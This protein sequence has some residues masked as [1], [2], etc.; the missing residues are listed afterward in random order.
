MLYSAL[1]GALSYS[2]YYPEEHTLPLLISMNNSIIGLQCFFLTYLPLLAPI[3][4]QEIQRLYMYA[5]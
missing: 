2:V 5:V 3:Q 1:T 4:I